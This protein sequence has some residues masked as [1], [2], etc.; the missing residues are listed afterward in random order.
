M[1]NT[2][3]I[4]G[5]PN[6]GKS[7]LFNRLIKQRDA[8]VEDEPGV[9]RDRL[10]GRV[11]WAGHQF[12]LIDTGGLVP[13]SDELFE[14]AVRNQAQIALDE[15]HIILFIVDARSGLTAIDKDIA[16][17]VRKASKPVLLVVNKADNDKSE[18]EGVE[19]Y[20]LGLGD[21][22][23]VSAMNG[24]GTGDL[25]D[26]IVS[27]LPEPSREYEEDT[28][29]KLALL[30]RP[31]VGKSSITNELLGE[32]RSIVTDVPGTTRDSVDSIVKYYG[33]EIVLVDTAGLRRRK[34]V[35]ESIELYSVVR[36]IKAIDRCDVAVVV[37]DAEQGFDRQDARIITEAVERR[38]GVMIVVNKWDLIQKDSN[39][40]A[41]YEKKIYERIAMLSYIP[42]LFV[43]ALTRQRLTNILQIAKAVHEERSKRITTSELNDVILR[44][45]ENHPPPA[46]K[47]KDLRI[48][49]IVQ[50]QAVPPVFLCFTNHPGLVPE[51][52]T[53]YLENVIRERYGFMG[54]PI[55][56]V[57]K[58][59][60]RMREQEY[61]T[62]TL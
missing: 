47:G 3:A 33:E 1:S 22:Y 8:I 45:I 41:K 2:V 42:I 26:E 38:R 31:N 54:A 36:T 11:E 24:R 44:A 14:Y 58:Q 4:I 43:S 39:T 56:I 57:Y 60:N 30:G 62:R 49:F 55:T 51:H 21:P 40:A 7:T 16:D 32:E 25:L 20:E 5:R 17:F 29:L 61:S 15:A 34:K 27:L 46:V 28:R 19:F 53:R 12:T 52:Y 9:T 35:N 50:P 13:N 59:K 6:V 10:Y 18:E 37:I 23:A 48:N